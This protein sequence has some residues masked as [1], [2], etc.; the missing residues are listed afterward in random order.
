VHTRCPGW[1]W[2]YC[3]KTSHL[4]LTAHQFLA[5]TY[6]SKIS[7]CTNLDKKACNPLP[8]TT[9]GKPFRKDR[10][11]GKGVEG[12][13]L[14]NSTAQFLTFNTNSAL[15]LM[16]P[17]AVTKRIKL[18]DSMIWFCS[19]SSSLEREKEDIASTASGQESRML[20]PPGALLSEAS[21]SFA[22][23]SPPQPPAIPW[24]MLLSELAPLPELFW[25]SGAAGGSEK[26][27][28]AR[29]PSGPSSGLSVL[30]N[31]LC[32]VILIK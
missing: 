12:S 28:T 13:T 14:W 26:K 19:S 1:T 5:K 22:P 18:G 31:S 32:C 30:D 21:P 4:F 16:S 29:E 11:V 9:K 23:F 15:A 2:N 10:K 17:R 3:S 6:S 24:S 25:L 27:R 8:H 7:A 20:L